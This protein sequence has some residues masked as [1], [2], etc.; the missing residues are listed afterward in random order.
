MR[1]KNTKT[2]KE[3]TSQDGETSVLTAT[4]TKNFMYAMAGRLVSFR[5]G[6]ILR[7]RKLIKELLQHRLPIELD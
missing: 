6:V 1:K 4:I 5:A 3:L 2:K 7:D